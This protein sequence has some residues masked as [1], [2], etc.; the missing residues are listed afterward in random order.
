MGVYMLETDVF[1]LKFLNFCISATRLYILLK[2][3]KL[4]LNKLHLVLL[5]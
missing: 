4:A 5:K 2:L 1:K 3:L